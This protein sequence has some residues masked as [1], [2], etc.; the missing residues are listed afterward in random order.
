M[1]DKIVQT[2]SLMVFINNYPFKNVTL[3]ATQQRY[4]SGGDCLIKGVMWREIQGL[5][6]LT[7]ERSTADGQIT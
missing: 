7:V 5:K 3:I 2:R 4:A 1:C 6:V